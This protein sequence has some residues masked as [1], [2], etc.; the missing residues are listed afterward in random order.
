MSDILSSLTSFLLLD[1]NVTALVSTRIYPEKLP[2][3][4]T[5]NPTTMPA[6]TYQLIDEPVGTTHDNNQT[7]KARIQLD[8]W[9]GSYKSA[10]SVADA[11]H[12]SMQ[13]YRGAMGSVH[14]GGVF[15]QRKT[16]DSNADVALFRVSQDY[17]INYH[18][19]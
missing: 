8:A 2:A 4:S 19:E 13:G 16:D 6:L 15:R 14:V 7:F 5:D 1:A 10:H 12:T 3:G 17:M 11:L 9:G 18:Q